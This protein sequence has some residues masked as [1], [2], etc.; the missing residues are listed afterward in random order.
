M[1]EPDGADEAIDESA[2][3]AR[4]DGGTTVAVAVA[5]I[6]FLP[7]PADTPRADAERRQFTESMGHMARAL[8]VLGGT[9]RIRRTFELRLVAP[10]ESSAEI[11]MFFLV[12]SSVPN[13]G[14]LS[15]S[16]E[17]DARRDAARTLR[18][19]L[20][21]APT[22][23]TCSKVSWDATS[24]AAKDM[25]RKRAGVDTRF[26]WRAD[27]RKFDL[28]TW[29]TEL[30]PLSRGERLER[31]RRSPHNPR[32]RRR[33]VFPASFPRARGDLLPVVSAMT[34]APGELMIRILLTPTKLAQN[35][36]RAA[37]LIQRDLAVRLKENAPDAVLAVRASSAIQALLD[38][39]EV[40]AYQ[41]AVYG[42]DV[43]SVRSVTAAWR[44]EFDG[45]RG[46]SDADL[47]VATEPVALS[48][49]T[50][51]RLAF[52]DQPQHQRPTGP[53]D[54]AGVF[55]WPSPQAEEPGREREHD[56]QTD[57]GL[58]RVGSLM[59]AA[60]AAA[61]WRLPAV[62]PGGQSGLP[63]R[64]INPFEQLP[65][66]TDH[67]FR[68]HAGQ[69]IPIGRVR[70]RG[71]SLAADFVLPVSDGN[72]AGVNILDRVMLVV[73]A[74]GSGKTNFACTVL[75]QIDARG[76]PF[77]V[78]DPTLGGEFRGLSPGRLVVYTVGERHN[79]LRFNPF[80]VPSNVNLQTHI[81]RLMTCFRSAFWMWDP[82]PAIFEQAITEAYSRRLFP[83]G[84]PPG[85]RAADVKG[86]DLAGRA[87][88][89]RDVARAMG[90]G[91]ADEKDTVLAG[92]GRMWSAGGNAT[93]NQSTILASTSMRLSSLERNYG[94][95]IGDSGPYTDVARL[96]DT[97]TVLE[98][99]AI[100][101]GQALALIASFLLVSVVGEIETADR[102]GYHVLVLEEAHRL[103]AGT[104]S[105]T[106]RAESADSSAQAAADLNNL[107]AEVRKYHQ[108]VMI[109]DQRP[110]SLVGGVIDNAYLV[111]MHRLGERTGFEH[112]SD[113]LN[114][115]AEQ[116]RF[117]RVGLD[118]GEAVVLDRLLG[119]PVLIRPEVREPPPEADWEVWRARA[120]RLLSDGGRAAVDGDRARSVLAKLRA[121]PDDTRRLAALGRRLRA[122]VVGSVTVARVLSALTGQPDLDEELLQAVIDIL[123]EEAH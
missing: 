82:L 92:I 77:L 90:T 73:G 118:V 78:I 8:H 81:T 122:D 70:H 71:Y 104:A 107:L 84:R 120:R 117:A 75:D 6:P 30:D 61:L 114:L 12:H 66:M 47:P 4:E 79:P 56:Q 50:R 28:L 123:R 108:G 2:T 57:P 86:A 87:P 121:D 67:N 16:R 35:E 69:C 95:I 11:A 89:L 116:R 98:F 60:E 42:E 103:L 51:G 111:A 22:R 48:D 5:E 83:G 72:P 37:G 13:D 39:H 102:R 112:L 32:P 96:L 91:A 53:E 106:A 7:E 17:T 40:F 64:P 46:R 110:G 68:E 20:S 3:M 27:L 74:P 80:A 29:A 52:V 94:H 63:S 55:D 76:T 85:W 18:L 49:T 26:G 31:N 21:L 10:R 41:A 43:E 100:G 19:V 113:M 59:S 1:R 9:S 99:G 97:P 65:R 119:A 115:N 58:L 109:L 44:M 23:L 45:A 14:Q 54:V 93:E 88:T 101:D 15:S 36:Y 24:G 38:A 25:I 62:R 105:S 33:H 34:G